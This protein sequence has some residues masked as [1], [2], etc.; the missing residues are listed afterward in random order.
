MGD[1]SDDDDDEDDFDHQEGTNRLHEGNEDEEEEDGVEANFAT[2][3]AANYAPESAANYA[4]YSQRGLYGAEVDEETKGE[5]DEEQ[6]RENERCADEISATVAA[7]PP[8]SSLAVPPMY[9]TAAAALPLKSSSKR[10]SK[11]P[12]RCA[13]SG[14]VSAAAG[15]SGGESE[16]VEKLHRLQAEHFKLQQQHQFL[17]HGEPTAAA[18]EEGESEAEDLSAT[19][20]E[21]AAAAA[22]PGL[23]KAAQ[24]AFLKRYGFP[25]NSEEAIK[26][27]QRLI[28][29]WTTVAGPFDNEEEKSRWGCVRV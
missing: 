14:V 17:Q 24:M 22:A 19:S 26:L 2:E 1:D 8:S 4:S 15:T 27:S 28:R 20:K 29:Q 16:Y 6:K 11:A 18:D 5:S 23:E 7:S 25:P 12:T 3:S 13:P 9:A 10:K 21:A